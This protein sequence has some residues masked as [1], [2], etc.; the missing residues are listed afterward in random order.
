MRL[1]VTIEQR[2]DRTPDGAIWT[3]AQFPYK[4]WT[5]YLDVFDEVRV[6][7]RV[8]EVLEVPQQYQRADGKNVIFSAL[9]YYL[10]PFAYL[11][12]RAK[13]L[14][15][16]KA[17]VTFDHAYLL[18]VSSQIGNLVQPILKRREFP[19]GAQVVCDP[20]DIFAPGVVKH[21]LS[22]FF[23]L[24]FSRRLKKQCAEASAVAYVTSAYLQK[25]YPCAG[26]SFSISGVQIP[27]DALVEAPRRLK[28]DQT[29]F[30]LV[31]VGSL[32]Q[33]YKAPD[34]LIH[35]V[36][37]CVRDGLD[38]QLMMI[39]SGK[40]QLQLQALV[41]KEGIEDRV[42]FAGQ[43]SNNA[44][45]R[46]YL[47]EADLFVLPS[48]TE[49]LPR[50]VIEAMARGLPCIGSSAGGIPELLA[51]EDLVQPG[52]PVTLTTKIKEV[53]NNPERMWEMSKRNLEKSK[54]Y[55]LNI[56]HAKQREFLLYLR[57]I[58]KERIATDA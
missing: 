8:Q 4:V 37:N 21:P 53:L 3:P 38:L 18:R 11:K 52:D 14:K 30:R 16:I 26:R 34:V 25:R 7:A 57:D 58:T 6:L 35:A 31:F 22:P 50:A 51:G 43:I 13:L 48:R 5:Q 29:T 1:T 44:T 10:G 28:S 27:D 20:F 36:G 45:L 2:Y 42:T 40:F 39:G 33:L 17:S 55:R 15:I 23:R 12:Q 54:M 41:E 49:G 47:D 56:M 32:A 19:Y 46:H 24:L 9:P